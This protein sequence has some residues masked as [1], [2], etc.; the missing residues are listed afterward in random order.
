REEDLTLILLLS[1][2][3][4]R[5]F[6]P[7]PVAGHAGP[8]QHEQELVVDAYGFVDL[9]EDLSPPSHVQRRIPDAELLLNHSG[10]KSCGELVVPRTVTDEAR[11]EL[12]RLHRADQGE[13]VHDHGLRHTA[14]A[15]ELLVDLSLGSKERVDP[16][17][18]WSIVSDCF[19]P[20]HLGQIDICEYRSQ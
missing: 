12:D 1:G 18:A 13:S 3:R 15:E 2:N 20:I 8:R 11:V 14:T 6:V 19:Q 9:V 4:P 10:V 7:H 5:D 17:R 16:D